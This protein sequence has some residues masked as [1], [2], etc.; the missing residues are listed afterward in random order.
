MIAVYLEYLVP[1]FQC[2]E[3]HLHI[4]A[5]PVNTPLAIGGLEF[6]RQYPQGNATHAFAAV[7]AKIVLAEF[8]P[9]PAQ[10][11]VQFPVTYIV[12]KKIFEPPH[13]FGQVGAGS[14]N[15]QA[16]F[17][18]HYHGASIPPFHYDAG[19]K[20]YGKNKFQN[21]SSHSAPYHRSRIPDYRRSR[22][23]M[24][25]EDSSFMSFCRFIT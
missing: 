13:S 10:K 5:I 4:R 24:W 8:P 23:R 7:G 16:W 14:K 1:I 9:P 15:A 12:S 19:S 21:T 18:K 20:N 17:L 25:R 2:V 11:P 6:L 22:R 3:P